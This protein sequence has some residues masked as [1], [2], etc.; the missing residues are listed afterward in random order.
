QSL[1]TEVP[2]AGVVLTMTL[3][4]RLYG[5]VWGELYEHFV[6]GLAESGVLYQMEVAAICAELGFQ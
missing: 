6:P 2:A 1:P 3:W 4:A 5:V